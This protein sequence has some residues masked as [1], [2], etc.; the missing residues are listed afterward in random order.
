MAKR[1]CGNGFA[2]VNN[3]RRSSSSAR[4]VIADTATVAIHA[5]GKHGASNGD[6]P[7]VATKR[8]PKVGSIIA[9]GSGNTAAASVHRNPV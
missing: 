5:A 2:S 4:T 6:A 8:V 9:I 7:T 1:F 3:A